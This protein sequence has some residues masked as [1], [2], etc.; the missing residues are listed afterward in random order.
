MPMVPASLEPAIKG[1]VFD[2]LQAQFLADVPPEH[3]QQVTD[4]HTKMAV[5]V[6]KVAAEVINNI[7]S[8]LMLAGTGVVQTTDMTVDVAGAGAGTGTGAG[9][10]TCTASPGAFT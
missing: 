10:G 9:S 6:S 1:V 5:C 2:E 7:K 3:Q 4:Q 8:F